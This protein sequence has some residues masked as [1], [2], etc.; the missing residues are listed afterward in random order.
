VTSRQQ[1]ALFIAIGGLNTLFGYSLYVFFIYIGM[2]YYW[3]M[4]LTTCCGVLFNFKTTGKIVFKNANNRLFLR[5]I[6]VYA[7]TYSFNITVI[8]FMQALTANM[9][10]AGFVAMIPATIIAFLLN[11]FV[12]FGKR[13]EAY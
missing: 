5:F 10:L 8:H 6:A 4:L 7:L 3:A 11:K 2:Y 1:I 9:Y 12:V 13:Y